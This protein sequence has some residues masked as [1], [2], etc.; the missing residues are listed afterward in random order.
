MANQ[1]V[2]IE[3]MTWDDLDRIMRSGSKDI[4]FIERARM[5]ILR[6]IGVNKSIE[7]MTERDLELIER[8]GCK[9]EQF[10]RQIRDSI[11]AQK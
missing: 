2:V 6:R 7:K 8:S 9:D 5:A 1:Q 4:G 11:K 3:E 10:L